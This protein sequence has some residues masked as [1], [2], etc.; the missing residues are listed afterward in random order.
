MH[1]TDRTTHWRGVCTAQ[2]H[3]LKKFTIKASLR[4]MRRHVHKMGEP[5]IYC[6]HCDADTS[7]RWERAKEPAV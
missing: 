3:R 6:E 5:R 1:S 4:E 2:G 7:V